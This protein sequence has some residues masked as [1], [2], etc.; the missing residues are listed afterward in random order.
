M[1]GAQFRKLPPKLACL[2][3]RTTQG[4]TAVVCLGWIGCMAVWLTLRYYGSYFC[5]HV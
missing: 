5:L 4:H 3:V 1:G 2:D